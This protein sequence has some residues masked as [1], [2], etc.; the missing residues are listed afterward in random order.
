MV[1][2]ALMFCLSCLSCLSCLLF[3]LDGDAHRFYMSGANQHFQ[4]YMLY[5][6]RVHQATALDEDEEGIVKVRRPPECRL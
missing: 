1:V 6:P 4:M 5:K 3:V 2:E